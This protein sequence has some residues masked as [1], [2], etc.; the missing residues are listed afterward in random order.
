MKRQNCLSNIGYV[1]KILFHCAPFYVIWKMF[2]A[3]YEGALG[4]VGLMML[5]HILNNIENQTNLVS[6]I[7]KLV[8]YCLFIL[9]F[10]TCIFLVDIKGSPRL[11]YTAKKHITE[12]MFKTATQVEQKM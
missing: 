12:Q 9:F 4:T 2:V 7:W 8:F 5:R 1:L 6:S 11:T 10:Q 3:V